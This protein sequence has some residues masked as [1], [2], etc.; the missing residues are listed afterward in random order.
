M[1]TQLPNDFSEFLSSLNDA[2]ADYLLVGE[3][4]VGFHGYARVTGD[5]DLW[6]RQTSENANRVV[7]AITAFGF[8]D[9]GLSSSRFLGDGKITR[10]GLPP[11][12]IEVMTSIDGVSFDECWR[13]RVIT[14]WDGISVPVIDL[15]RLRVDKRPS[16]RPKDLADLDELPDA[17]DE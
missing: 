6:V 14:D 5:M 11:Y 4:A 9:E 16:G 17:P 7:A 2:R 10:M 1:E 8:K 3:Y 13:T 15:A 12:R